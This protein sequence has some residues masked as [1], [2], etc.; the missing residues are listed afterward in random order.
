MLIKRA[1]RAF[2]WPKY[3]C[4]SLADVWTVN[5]LVDGTFLD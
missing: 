3:A 5:L 1:H 2:C 4:I